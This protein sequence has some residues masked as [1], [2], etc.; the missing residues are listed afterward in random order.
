MSR[1]KGINCN[2]DS[3]QR[4]EEGSEK[5]KTDK[6]SQELMEIYEDDREAESIDELVPS[7]IRA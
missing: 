7:A 2:T 4:Q 5:S 6:T 3:Y 1:P